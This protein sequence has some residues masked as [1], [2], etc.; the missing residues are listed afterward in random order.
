MALPIRQGATHKVVIGPAVAVGDGFTPVTTLALTTA[1][2]AEV[3][4]HDNGTVVSISAYTFAAITT[5]DGYYHLTLQSG[6]SGTV[7][8]MTVVINDDS[9]CLP[10]RTDFVVLDTGIYDSIYADAAVGLATQASVDTIDT[11]VDAILVD[12]G[13]TLQAELDAIE[14]AVITNAAGVDI[15]ADIIALKAE[16]AA[17]LVDTGTTLDAALAV[18]DGNVDAILVDTGTTLQAELDAIE[19]AV[20][21][22]AAGVDIAADI[23]A[24]KAETAAILVDTGTTLDGAITTID[25]IVDAILVDTGTTLQAE[26][27]AIEA[28]VITNAAGVDIA[29]DIIALKAETAAI[30]ADTDDI[31]VAGAG[32]TALATQA[33]VDTIDGIVDSILDDTDLIDDATSGLA[34]I[35]TD[36]AAVLVDT[37]TTLQAE[38]DGIQADTENIQSRLPAAL[39]GG[40]IDATVDDTGLEAGAAGVIADAVWNEDATGHQTGGTFGQAIGDP[41]ANTET[42]Y[43]AVVTDAAGTNVAADIVAVKAE[44]ASILDDTDLIDDGT[45]GL[46]KIAT[47]VAAILVD[48]STTLQ[49]ELDGIQADTEDLQTQIGTA[50]AGLTDLGGMSTTM[51]GQVNT[52]V[53]GAFTT[54]MADSVSSDGTIATREQALYLLLQFLT[55]FGIVGTTLTAY[56]VDGTTA[57]ATFTLDDDTTPTAITR[58]T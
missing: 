13:T 17:I 10:I 22:N 46:A 18:V 35:A 37:S 54:Q 9:L 58:S 20:I 7:G 23:I 38:L 29:A 6:I 25:G 1:D 36:V 33:S 2:E 16:T 27:D 41:G 28:A 53:D 44:T 40:R 5:A 30:L 19:A 39:V 32:L 55:E 31:G 11:N 47:D 49:A 8:H 48:T 21:T 14:A 24:L 34:K 50:G 51:K 57:L 15:A 52:E 56:K 43:D 12:T 3:I 26:L 42:M 45:S 4:L